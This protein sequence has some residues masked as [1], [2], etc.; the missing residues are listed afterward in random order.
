VGEF[1]TERDPDLAQTVAAPALGQG[2]DDEAD[3]LLVPAL[4]KFDRRQLWSDTVGLRRPPGAGARASRPTLERDNQKTRVHEPLESTAG[5]IA[6]DPLR[7]GHLVRR[8]GKR[9]R[10]GEEE[11]LA[12]LA[13]TDRIKPMHHFLETW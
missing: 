12:Q 11:R 8:H 7:G 6:V 5:D 13:I 10:A 1:S 2:I 4:R 9:L 3:Q